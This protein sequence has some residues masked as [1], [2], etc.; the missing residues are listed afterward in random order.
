MDT[1]ELSK[2]VAT[3]LNGTP[4]PP[5]PPTFDYATIGKKLQELNH[6]IVHTYKFNKASFNKETNDFTYSFFVMFTPMGRAALGNK[7]DRGFMKKYHPKQYKKGFEAQA[8]FNYDRM[9]MMA[10]T[11]HQKITPESYETLDTIPFIPN[12]VQ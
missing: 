8:V 3:I 11:V 2:Q 7:E 10:A 4:P 9:S 6:I 12:H 1:T 5:K